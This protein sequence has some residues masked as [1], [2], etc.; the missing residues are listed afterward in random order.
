MISITAI[1]NGSL[2]ERFQRASKGARLHSARKRKPESI[3][4]KVAKGRPAKAVPS[5]AAA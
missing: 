4:R 1:T 3:R 5:V 2:S